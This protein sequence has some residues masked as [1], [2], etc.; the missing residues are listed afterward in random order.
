M[1]KV[2]EYIQRTRSSCPNKSSVVMFD[3]KLN[4]LSDHNPIVQ[5][6]VQE[7][8]C[9]DEVQAIYKAQK[10]ACSNKVQ[11][12]YEVQLPDSP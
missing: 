9:S 10:S 6:Q 1:C 8:A 11:A 5:L 4:Q 2:M 12:I 7:S 3:A